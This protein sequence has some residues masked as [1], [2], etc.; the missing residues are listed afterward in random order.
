MKNIFNLHPQKI[1]LDLQDVDLNFSANYSAEFLDIPP[2]LEAFWELLYRNAQNSWEENRRKKIVPSQDEFTDDYLARHSERF[3]KLSE[4]KREGVRAR[5]LKTYPSLVRE[6][7]FLS[8]VNYISIKHDFPCTL[9][10]SNS[11]LDMSKG[12]DLALQMQGTSFS[13]RITKTDSST[14]WESIK[15]KRKSDVSIPH[16]ITVVASDENT[17]WVGSG[18]P[19]YLIKKQTVKDVL[20]ECHEVASGEVN[21]G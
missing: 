2:M 9:Q 8:S 10:I 18:E 19:I 15:E 11:W 21:D 13:I 14:D 1:E 7:H 5:V 20:S 3:E 4:N 17:F 12:V 16:S 6:F